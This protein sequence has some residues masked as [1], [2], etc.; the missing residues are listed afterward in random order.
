MKLKIWL[1]IFLLISSAAFAS[2][3]AA[4]SLF[5]KGMKLDKMSDSLTEKAEKG[6]YWGKKK[7]RSNSCLQDY[8]KKFN[9]EFGGGAFELVSELNIIRYTGVDFKK[10]MKEFPKSS[11]AGEADLYI[12]SRD[13]VGNPDVVLP[14]VEN[15]LDRHP[16]GEA[17]RKGLLLSARLNQD[18]WWIHKKWSWVL[19]NGKV[20]EEELATKAEVYREKALKLFGEVSQKFG[21]SAEGKAARA[22]SAL[23]KTGKD[24]GKIYGIINESLTGTPR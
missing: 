18:I 14:K 8:V 15:F 11:Y 2:D 21:R 6:C 3:D 22:E 7:E 13:L 20:S 12:V 5:D 4:K 24:D 1:P 9:A 23:L 16:S 17:Y 19:Y 10:L